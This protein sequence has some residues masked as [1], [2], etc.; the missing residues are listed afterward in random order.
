MPARCQTHY[1]L[2][3]LRSLT[4]FLKFLGYGL[5]SASG[6]VGQNQTAL[7]TH[8][9]SSYENSVRPVCGQNAPIEVKVGVAVRQIIE[10]V[11][12]TQ[13]R[14]NNN[15]DNNNDIL[16][17]SQREIKAVVRSHNEEHISIILSHETHTH[18]HSYTH[19]HTLRHTP[20]FSQSAYSNSKPCF[21]TA[22][23]CV[24]IGILFAE[25]T[26]TREGETCFR[27]AHLCVFCF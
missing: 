26:D 20:P 3:I 5:L 6:V 24:L 27:T 19:I 14:E 25:L 7:M 10:L 22:H 17:S 23:L 18:T 11:M 4:T 8:L 16:Y 12:Y 1:S 9:F 15:N 21:R 13:G 2:I